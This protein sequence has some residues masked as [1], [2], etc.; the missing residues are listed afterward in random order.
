MFRDRNIS[1][2]TIGVIAGRVHLALITTN[3]LFPESQNSVSSLVEHLEEF[4]YNMAL[5]MELALEQVAG[6][7]L[8]WIQPI[9][10][11]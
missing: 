10:Q 6:G 9:Y 2:L 3:H 5:V 7:G 8:E 4:S 1:K 11:Q